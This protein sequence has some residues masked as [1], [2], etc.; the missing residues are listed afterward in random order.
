MQ[1]QRRH[2]RIGR[3][4]AATGSRAIDGQ[5]L[6]GSARHPDQVVA[7]RSV[8]LAAGW[9]AVTQTRTAKQN[10]ESIVTAVKRRV[11]GDRAR[12]YRHCLDEVVGT[13]T[14]RMYVHKLLSTVSCRMPAIVLLELLV[15]V[16]W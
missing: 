7:G 13:Q 16:S 15:P 4:S 8:A 3:V 9:N 12:F 5:T 1:G 2:W 14:Y 10:Q 6:G 11:P